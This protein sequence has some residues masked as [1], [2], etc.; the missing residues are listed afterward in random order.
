MKYYTP[1]MV[2]R[3][4]ADKL[5]LHQAEFDEEWDNAQTAYEEA[6]SKLKDIPLSVQKLHDGAVL[7]GERAISI[8]KPDGYHRGEEYVLVTGDEKDGVNHIL[9]YTVEKTPL[10]T[11]HEGVGFDPAT[12]PGIWLYDEFGLDAEGNFTHNVIFTN[13]I[14]LEVTFKSLHWI[15]ALTQES[16]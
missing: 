12:T 4:N 2:N 3:W 8:P 16:A 6:F 10:L 14:E 7:Y 15:E 5:G 13:G 11:V 1:D 9:V